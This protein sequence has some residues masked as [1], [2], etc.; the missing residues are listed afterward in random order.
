MNSWPDQKSRKSL[1]VDIYLGYRL[2]D[3]LP[4]RSEKAGRFEKM[5]HFDSSHPIMTRVSRAPPHHTLSA[6][7]NLNGRKLIILPWLT[8]HTG[9]WFKWRPYAVKS[10]L[11]ETTSLNWL[12]FFGIIPDFILKPLIE[13]KTFEIKFLALKKLSFSK[14]DCLFFTRC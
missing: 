6:F 3:H 5:L 13:I 7:L 4:L 11:W 14:A 12:Q 1:Y 8:S 2:V 10:I 9:G